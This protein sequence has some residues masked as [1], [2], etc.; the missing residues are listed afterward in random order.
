MPATSLELS[1]SAASAASLGSTLLLTASWLRARCLG[2]LKAPRSVM[3]CRSR[4]VCSGQGFSMLL[5]L[6]CSATAAPTAQLWA[7]GFMNPCV[8]F[9]LL[10]LL[11]LPILPALRGT[12]GSRQRPAGAWQEELLRPVL[13]HGTWACGWPSG[14]CQEG[15]RLVTGIMAD[16]QADFCLW[17]WQAWYL[18][19]HKCFLT[20]SCVAGIPLSRFIACTAV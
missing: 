20:Q 5:L 6:G 1:T 19:A 16:I 17:G 10:L 13:V 7:L 14:H 2:A 4:Q 11:L 15:P 8:L 3:P 9:Q 18:Q 12:L